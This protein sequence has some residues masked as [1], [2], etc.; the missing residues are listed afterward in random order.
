MKGGKRGLML[1][2]SALSLSLL[3]GCAGGGQS[4]EPGS[5][6]TGEAGEN[7]KTVI[8]VTFR[9]DGIGENGAFY[10]WLKEVSASYP[11][12]D[13][14]IKPTPIQASEGDYFAKVA[15]A[16]KSTETAPDIVTEDT[17]ILNS[18]ASAGYL[19]PLDDRLQDWEDWNNGS[20]IEAMKKGVTAS[21]GKVY[22]VPYN[23]DSRGLWYNKEIFKQVGLPEDWQ[24]K[25]WEEV[26]NAARTIKEQAPDIVPIWMNMGKAT[27]EAT[28]MQTYEMLLYGT[29]ERLYDDASGKWIIKSQGILDALGFV[30][31]VNKEGLGPPLSKVLNG[32]A[33][34][35]ASREYLPQG[36]LAISLDG[37]WITGNYLETG[38]APW[39]EY[40]DV[41]GFA[42]MP[43]S[44]GQPPGSI[45]LAGGWALSIPSNSKN[46][47]E[48]WEFIKYALNKDNTQKL[49]TSS[50]N[51]TVRTDVAKDPGYT[52][53]PFNEIATAYL[54]NA[55]FRPSQEKYPEVS[56]QI[57]TMVEA[58]AT[59]TSPQD[60]MNKYAQDVTRIVGAD[61]VVEK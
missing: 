11:N 24:P 48:A 59:G 50:G 42:P 51:I 46:K 14:E 41:L 49:V 31:T 52:Q 38:A 58:V 60:A 32:Q 56:T 39:P 28:S 16:L 8:S 26:L 27:G 12:P 45:T 23:T 30:E 6:E 55:D 61:N 21:D 37:S 10:K 33:G 3:F 43:T 35:T 13:V 53:M 57:Q 5:P 9:D 34:N 54:Q 1:I 19:E 7:A 36:K 44:E 17:F 18:D 40:K 47:D 20:F 4:S 2:S 15:L 22:G 25:S 29:G